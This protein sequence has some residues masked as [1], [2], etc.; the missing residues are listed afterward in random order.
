[1]CVQTDFTFRNCACTIPQIETCPRCPDEAGGYKQCRD[2]QLEKVE[3][4]SQ[5]AICPEES[6]TNEENKVDWVERI[7]CMAAFLRAILKGDRSSEGNRDLVDRIGPGSVELA[8]MDEMR[9][10]I[11][12]TEPVRIRNLFFCQ[13]WQKS[14]SQL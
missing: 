10:R 3:I 12:V 11:H 13:E 6:S 14:S 9:I 4:H 8:I 5:C 1:M 2:Y 7:A